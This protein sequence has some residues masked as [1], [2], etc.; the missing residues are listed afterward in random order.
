MTVDLLLSL[1]IPVL[2]V[3][4][5]CLYLAVDDLEPNRRLAAILKLA[6]L[7]TGLGALGLLG[8]RR[9]RKARLT[10]AEHSA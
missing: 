5:A 3:I 4:G 9:K 2:I 7:A 6:I 1:H 8:W 10:V